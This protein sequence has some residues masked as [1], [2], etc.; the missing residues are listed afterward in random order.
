M[1]DYTRT[2]KKCSEMKECKI[3]KQCMMTI[4]VAVGEDAAKSKK[5]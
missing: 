4:L 2:L 1:K 5:K 3:A